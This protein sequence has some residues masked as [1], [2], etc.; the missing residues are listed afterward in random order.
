MALRTKTEWSDWIK[1]SGLSA[2][3]EQYGAALA[4]EAIT[5]ED[6]PYFDHDLLKSCAIDKY[7]HRT[8][9]IRKAL[10]TSRK[11]VISVINPGNKEIAIPRP[12]VSKGVTQLEFE[13]FLYEWKQFKDH[14]NF[15]SAEELERQLIFC[16]AKE[17]RAKIR[18]G[19][20]LSAV[21]S[22]DELLNVI[23]D[24]VL[25]KVSRMTNIKKFLLAKQE[26]SESCEDYFSRLQTMATC[27]EFKCKNCNRST[28][29]ERV[30]E[31]FVLG[32]KDRNLQTT[33]LRT[34]TH[35]P[36]SPSDS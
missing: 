27:C 28:A 33:I 18:E 1:D 8:K 22:E 11:E 25:T 10:G 17:V 32:L 2:E 30:R 21:Y 20:D 14:Y 36:D 12:S 35:K 13:Q 16:C 7:G 29:P 5:E 31:K 15:S 23:K 9:I 24:I 4:A 34:E 26:I 3:A 6:L 19:R